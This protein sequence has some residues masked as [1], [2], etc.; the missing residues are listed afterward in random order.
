MNREYLDFL[1]SNAVRSAASDP[2][3]YY[4]LIR[5]GLR[6]DGWPKPCCIYALLDPET[7]EIRYI[8]KTN[9]ALSARRG[10]Q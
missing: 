3:A 9:Q 1:A 5:T 8:G 4:E 10:Q 6:P 7:D 2:N